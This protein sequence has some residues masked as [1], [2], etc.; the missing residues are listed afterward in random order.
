MKRRF[1]SFINRFI[2]RFN[3]HFKKTKNTETVVFENRRFVG[4]LVLSK[5]KKKKVY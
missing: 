2:N 3:N 5:K 1:Y 4:N